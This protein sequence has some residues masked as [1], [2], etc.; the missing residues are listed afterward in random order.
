MDRGVSNSLA[1]SLNDSTNTSHSYHPPIKSQQFSNKT[2]DSSDSSFSIPLN[3]DTRSPTTPAERTGNDFDFLP[4]VNFDDFQTSIA[5]YDGPLLAGFPTIASAPALSREVDSVMAGTDKPAGVKPRPQKLEPRDEPSGGRTDS[6]RRRFS[7]AAGHKQNLSRSVV[8]E[9]EPAPLYNKNPA[10]AAAASAGAS[11]R[12]SRKTLGPGALNSALDSRKPGQPPYSAASDSNATSDLARTG[13][14]NKI[15][16]R[17]V[18]QPSISSG[19]DLPRVSTL[20]AITQS[21]AN[22]VKNGTGFSRDPDPNTP[23]AR[24]VSKGGGNRAHTPSSSGN[25]RQSTVSGRA[26]G[27]GA[28]TTS[29][30]DTRRLKRLS[31]AQPPPVPVPSTSSKAPPTP[32]DELPSALK[33]EVPRL[34]QPSPSLIPRKTN[35]VTPSSARA[36]PDGR[37]GF[38]GG[39]NLNTLNTKTSHQSLLNSSA[40][41]SRLPTPKPRSVH[42]SSAQYGDEEMVPPVPAIPKAYG[43][44][45]ESDA[46]FFSSSVMSSSSVATAEP[47]LADFEIDGSFVSEPLESSKAPRKFADWLPEGRR[48][49]SGDQTRAHRRTNTL[50]NFD[51]SIDNTVPSKSPRPRL[52]TGGRKNSSLQPLRLPPLN[53]M[54]I[55]T[56]TTNKIFGFPRPSQE[57]E[58]RNDSLNAHTPEP[59]RN[60]KTPS[61]PMT[62]SKAT[63]WRRQDPEQ[64]RRKSLRSSS[65][66][67]ALRDF[68]Q[69]EDSLTKFYDDSDTENSGNG[70]TIPHLKPRNAITPFASGSLPRG[71]GDFARHFEPSVDYED[72]YGLGRNMNLQQQ[73]GKPQGPRPSRSGTNTSFKTAETGSSLESP[74]TDKG[75]SESKKDGSSGGLRRK[76]SMSW[77]RGG[78]KGTNQADTK[79]NPSAENSFFD[80][81]KSG[82][83]Q[84]RVNDMPP[85]KLPASATW[86]GDIPQ[87]PRPSFESSRR[88]STVT[89]ATAGSNG[90]SDK[91]QPNSVSTV[92]TK[93]L[94]SE[95]PQPVSA[96]N[97]AG[98]W[99]TA[100]AKTTAIKNR[101]ASS[102]IISATVKDKD[103]LAADEEMRRLS[104]KRRDVDDAARESDALKLRAVARTPMSP[105]QVLHDRDSTLNIFERGEIVD[106]AKDGIFFTGT[107]SARKI[108]GT[109]TPSP[110]PPTDDK[111][112]KGGNY[113]YDDERGD[114]NIVLGDHLAYRYEV[115]DV[116]GKGSF[117]QVV[118]CVD[119]KNGGVVA[120]KII[121]NKK[122]FHQQAL[123]E[124]GILNRLKDWVSVQILKRYLKRLLT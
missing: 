44:P 9:S 2:N 59:K 108:I 28:R 6:F 123:V 52:D 63:F 8:R 12:P 119:H 88:K 56:P 24:P 71:S 36:S 22:K 84:K 104:R 91:E 102:S 118:R 85:P 109:L 23:V 47:T 34:A 89:T 33:T 77:R 16:R 15:S 115:V 61:T 76:L 100:N 25:R 117:G 48:R 1:P 13:S 67:Y 4:A 32:Q 3:N 86:S 64:A 112:S 19:P 58:N 5:N 42:S 62:A 45:G 46:Q 124:V 35:S 57:V 66:Q 75:Q 17:N 122:R 113:G 39:V 95:Q 27:L 69:V 38:N 110:Q 96:S 107:K 7:A 29:P 80:K 72:D 74:I 82:K 73:I 30:T 21:H 103:D 81:E 26:S 37:F 121:R 40:S 98:S 114:Y 79:S 93:S 54:P 111:A 41:T 99:G 55:T 68:S 87:L 14:F 83:L 94:H 78:S 51:S 43:S 20:T 90:S 106:Y 116:L 18:L 60:A 120:V 70:V 10:T 92:K 31:L 50:E 97:R 11:V 101:S 53:L 105:S 49:P 65:S